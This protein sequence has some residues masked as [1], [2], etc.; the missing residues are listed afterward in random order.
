M[1]KRLSWVLLAGLAQAVLVTVAPARACTVFVL[2]DDE[3]TLFCNNE[4]WSNPKTRIWFKPVNPAADG[5]ARYGTVYVG[6]DNGWAQGGM[7]AEGLAFDWVAGF[8]ETWTPAHDDSLTGNRAQRMLESC[9]SVE[10]AIGFFQKHTEPAFSYAKILVADRS[11]ASAI[12]GAKDGKLEVIKAKTSGGFGYGSEVVRRML[13][14]DDS[15]TAENA[16]MLLRASQQQGKFAT[17]YSNVFNLRTGQIHIYQYHQNSTPT[18][19]D[20]KE[21]L[22]RGPHYFDMPRV[23]AEAGGNGKRLTRQM[24]RF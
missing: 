17:K 18:V 15:P 22:A 23:Q 1:G 11:G 10:E 8:K 12:I 3:N 4:D 2:T 7:N 20:L 19:L 24:R 13:L 14:G 6:F 21:Q 9:T 5:T 16:A